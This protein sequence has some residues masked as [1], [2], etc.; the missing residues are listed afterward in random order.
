MPCAFRREDDTTNSVYVDIAGLRDT[1]GDFVDYLNCLVSTQLFKSAKSVRFIV[2]ITFD[3]LMESRGRILKEQMEFIE[4][5]CTTDLQTLS[6]AILPVITRVKPNEE[7][8]DMD[9]IRDMIEEQFATLTEQRKIQLEQ[10]RLI[11]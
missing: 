8:F 11:K 1:N 9:F 4:N 5:L 10:E 3:S 7:N 6:A 2:A